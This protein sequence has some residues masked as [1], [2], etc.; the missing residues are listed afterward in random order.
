MH[1][2][3]QYNLAHETLT[4]IK[5][6]NISEP[7]LAQLALQYVIMVTSFKLLNERSEPHKSDHSNPCLTDSDVPTTSTSSSVEEVSNILLSI[8]FSSYFIHSVSH[9]LVIAVVTIHPLTIQSAYPLWMQVMNRLRLLL[10]V[11]SLGSCFCTT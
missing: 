7:Y 10:L 8:D 4:F 3:D 6:T 1:N 2:S 5:E 9:P 11:R